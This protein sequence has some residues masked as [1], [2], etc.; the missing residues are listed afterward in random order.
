MTMWQRVQE[1]AQAS[2]QDLLKRGG[3]P[4]QL[5]GQAI[6]EIE[7]EL[8]K[9][10]ADLEEAQGAAR[11]GMEMAETRMEEARHFEARAHQAQSQGMT[12]A[13]AELRA[14]GGRAK[15]HAQL[16]ADEA[17]KA[18]ASVQQLQ[19]ALAALKQTVQDAR[20]K[21]AELQARL[22]EI[23]ERTARPRVGP[24]RPSWV[25]PEERAK[26]VERELEDLQ[27]RHVVDEK[28]AELKRKLGGS[29]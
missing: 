3:D 27:R 26:D 22:K 2:V 16:L 23:R 11:V 25:G 15:A 28:L 5:L 6:A 29:D 9:S 12:A 17:R 10:S 1:L 14:F 8:G 7:K 20:S 4:D 24:A 21:R 13:A 19:D 18:Q